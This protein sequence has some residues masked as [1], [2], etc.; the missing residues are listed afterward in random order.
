M[1]DFKPTVVL[2]VGDGATPTEVFTAIDMDLISFTAPSSTAELIDVTDFASTGYREYLA[3]LK[4]GD[5]LEFVFHDD[6]TSTARASL[7]TDQGA[8]T[9]RNFELT[10][11]DGTNTETTSFGMVVQRASAQPVS[12]GEAARFVLS[13]KQSGASTSAVA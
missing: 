1:A 9:T 10:Y 4:D 13:G 2:K 5:D 6:L 12:A 11:S 8:G 7:I 3:G